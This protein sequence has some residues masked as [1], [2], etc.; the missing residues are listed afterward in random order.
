MRMRDDDISDT[1]TDDQGLD[2]IDR[3]VLE[4]FEE[5]QDLV[6]QPEDN[7]LLRKLET[8][9]AETP[10]VSGGDLDAAWDRDD[11][12]E[13][14]VGGST[15]TPDQDVVDELGEAVGITYQDTEPLHTED[16]L[17]ERDDE[18][19]ELDPRSRGEEGTT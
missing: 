12:G 1:G 18:R 6:P 16:K 13:E 2:P 19:W 17:R 14:G 11:I 4:D 15:P 7:L 8:H 10:E 3:E 5:V 9:T